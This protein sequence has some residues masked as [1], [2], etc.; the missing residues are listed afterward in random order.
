MSMRSL[1]VAGSP[2]APLQH[3]YLMDAGS[4][5]SDAHLIPVGKPA[6]PRPRRPERLT[7][8]IVSSGGIARAIWRASPPPRAMYSSSDAMVLSGRTRPGMRWRCS[9]TAVSDASGMGS[10]SPLRVVSDRPPTPD[11][12]GTAREGGQRRLPGRLAERTFYGGEH[13]RTGGG[14][15]G[16]R[17]RRPDGHR[18]AV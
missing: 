7:M 15:P 9:V 14:A 13:A 3:R 10:R 16:G 4:L 1:N 12:T 5:R 11:L 17:R 8:S 18:C 6:P 2:S